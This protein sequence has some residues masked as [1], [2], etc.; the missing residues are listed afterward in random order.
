M[1]TY[2]DFLNGGEKIATNILADRL[3]LLEVTGI[4]SKHQHPESKAKILYKLTTKGIDL[5]PALVEL[6]KWSEKYFDVHPHA[7]QF[8]LQLQNDH[9]ATVQKIM[10]DLKKS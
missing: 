2:G 6:I 8:V 9:H 7:R 3:N 4:I 1:K 5:V 10:D